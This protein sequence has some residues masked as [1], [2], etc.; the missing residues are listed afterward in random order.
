MTI[1][2]QIKRYREDRGLSQFALARALGKTQATV[3]GWEHDHHIPRLVELRALAEALGVS[4]ADILSVPVRPQASSP[5]SITVVPEIGDILAERPFEA[6]NIVGYVPYP[7]ESDPRGVYAHVLKWDV[8]DRSYRRGDTVF[9]SPDPSGR[10]GTRL[11]G[12][13]GRDLWVWQV[14]AEGGAPVIPA[15]GRI[16][17]SLVGFF[18][19]L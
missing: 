11:L 7:P 10:P 4:S 3:S 5:L 14:D 13:V 16:I 8:A 17:G 9:L 19:S 6:P 2:T 1:G 12:V 18:R 15:E